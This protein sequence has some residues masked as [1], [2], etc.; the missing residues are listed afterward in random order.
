MESSGDGAVSQQQSD[1][2]AAACGLSVADSPS[3]F[4]NGERYEYK[5][6]GSV[7]RI[8]STAHD[9]QMH[10]F[11]RDTYYGRLRDSDNAL[12]HLMTLSGVVKR[13]PAAVVREPR[14]YVS[15][16]TAASHTLPL[17]V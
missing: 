14:R 16:H 4:V 12:D 1:K 7:D 8:V 3:I 10:I 6:Y 17:G 15:L 11:Q 2:F 13:L 9:Q 5:Q